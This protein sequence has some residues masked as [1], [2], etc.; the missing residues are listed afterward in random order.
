[1]AFKAWALGADGSYHLWSKRASPSLLIVKKEEGNI[2]WKLINTLTQPNLRW[3]DKGWVCKQ[4]QSLR[5]GQKTR[6]LLQQNYK[7]HSK[8]WCDSVLHCWMHGAAREEVRVGLVSGCGGH[9]HQ[10]QS[11][12]GMSCSCSWRDKLQSSA[13][14]CKHQMRWCV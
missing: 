10:P 13:P 1:M 5:A 7:G 14:L 4:C 3:Q 2:R 6:L 11:H 9:Q 8:R 12:W